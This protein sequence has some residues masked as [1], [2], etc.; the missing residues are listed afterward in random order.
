MSK[1]NIFGGTVILKIDK[2]SK[3]LAIKHL[4]DLAINF[5]GDDLPLSGKVSLWRTKGYCVELLHY[6]L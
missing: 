4:D 2:N 6:I 1:I 5:P 3:L